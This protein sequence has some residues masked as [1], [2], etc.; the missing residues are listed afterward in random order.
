MAAFGPRPVASREPAGCRTA[1][2][3]RFLVTRPCTLLCGWSKACPRSRR[4]RTVRYI[5][6]CIQLAHKAGFRICQYAVLRNHLHF[7]LDVDDAQALARGMLGTKVRLARR[8][9]ALLGRTGSLFEGRYHVRPLTTP[10]E[11]R[12]G[13]L[14]VLSNARRHAAQRGRRLAGGWLDPYSSAPHFDGWAGETHTEPQLTGDAVTAAPK[15]WLLR[16]GWRQHGPLDPN[17]IP[18][19]GADASLGSRSGLDTDRRNFLAISE[20]RS[21]WP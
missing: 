15:S 10:Q 16:T 9:N 13:L 5:R 6:R 12:N 11:V 19:L 21:S 18:G 2:G 20:P 3:R 14:Y 17:R 1:P 8:L 7:I 4:P